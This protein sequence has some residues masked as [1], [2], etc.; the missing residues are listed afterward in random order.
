MSR[1]ALSLVAVSGLYGGLGVAAAAAAAHATADTRL[2]TASMFLM[3]H[4]AAIVAIA[5]AAKAFGLGRWLLLPGWGVAIGTLMFS[6]D[7]IVHV[8]YGASPLP[9][10]APIGG[11]LLIVSWLALSVGVAIGAIRR[12]A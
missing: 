4:A 11:T 9:L 10:V 7:L 6:G 1:S 12:A 8:A 2:Q 5:G 3:L